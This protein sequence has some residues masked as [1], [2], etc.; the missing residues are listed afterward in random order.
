MGVKNFA[1]KQAGGKN[2]K[3]IEREACFTAEA[4]T[5]AN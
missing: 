4:V 3:L 2:S 1:N 5:R